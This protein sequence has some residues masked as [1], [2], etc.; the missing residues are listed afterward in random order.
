MSLL[1]LE[2]IKDGVYAQ[3]EILSPGTYDIDNFLLDEEEIKTQTDFIGPFFGVDFA[4]TRG[5]FQVSAT[6]FPQINR[7]SENE[8]FSYDFYILCAKVDFATHYA[9]LSKA[10]NRFSTTVSPQSTSFALQIGGKMGTWTLEST[11]DL[12]ILWASRW[13][14]AI[15]TTTR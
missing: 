13:D 2:T 14:W 6:Q 12:M 4:A 8:I 10:I 3:L 5:K 9:N 1:A 11:N 15:P 7:F